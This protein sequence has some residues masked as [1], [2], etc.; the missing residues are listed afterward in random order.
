MANGLFG[1]GDGSA[2]NPY[3]IEDAADFDAIRNNL[4]KSFRMVAN[5]DLLVYTSWIPLGAY[6]GTLDGNGKILSGLT[7]RSSVYS[8]YGL[9]NYIT[10]TGVV[11]NLTITGADIQITRDGYAGVIA[12]DSNGLI[13]NCK[14]GGEMHVTL[15]TSNAMVGG[16]I[17]ETGA[18]SVIRNT[19]SS[20]NV[21][22]TDNG[23]SGS[24]SKVGG[25]VGHSANAGVDSIKGCFSTGKV[26]IVKG[27][28]YAGTLVGQL[29][30][31]MKDCYSTGDI[32]YGGGPNGWGVGSGSAAGLV[33]Y[34]ENKVTNCYSTGNVTTMVDGARDYVA[35]SIGN[36]VA[37]AV[38]VGVYWKAETVVTVQGV[39][40]APTKG[41]GSGV[42]DTLSRPQATMQSQAFLDELNLNKD[43]STVWVFDPAITNGFPTFQYAIAPA[44]VPIP[45]AP[46]VSLGPVTNSTVALS[47]PAVNGT[48]SYE[49]YKATVAGGPYTLD[50]STTNT[51]PMV[52][53]LTGSTTYYFVVKA[54][55]ASGASPN[56]NEVMATTT[57]PP[58]PPTVPPSPVL[59]V[60]AP[61]DVT[62]TS[63]LMS[64][65]SIAEAT[66]YSL[67]M[68]TI[69]GSLGTLVASGIINTYYNVTGLT[70]NTQYFFTATASN[71]NGESPRSAEMSSTTLP[72]PPVPPAPTDLAVVAGSITNTQVGLSWGASAGAAS[73]TLHQSDISGGLGFPVFSEI[74]T[75]SIQVSGLISGNTY[76]FTVTAV[77]ANGESMRSNEIT[78]TTLSPTPP[79]TTPDAP[80]A[81]LGVVTDTT[82]EVIVNS[83]PNATSYNMYRSTVSGEAI[84]VASGLIGTSYVHTG[85]TTNT[86][87]FFKAT[88][89]NSVGESVKSNE[90]SKQTDLPPA[91]TAI[92]SPPFGV[93]AGTYTEST[94]KIDWSKNPDT[95]SYSVYKS[96]VAGGPYELVVT[97]VTDL[98]YTV[99][100]L[101]SSTIYYFTVTAV[102]AIGESLMSYETTTTTGISTHPT[103]APSFPLG[104]R[105]T[106][107]SQTTVELA[108]TGVNQ[109]NRYNT[110]MATVSGGPYTLAYRG[111]IGESF[112]SAINNL[113]PGTN[114]YF[115]VTALNDIGEGPISQEVMATTVVRPPAPNKTTGLTLKS[116]TINSV[117]LYWDSQPDVLFYRLFTSQTS[118]GPWTEM[119]GNIPFTEHTVTGL[120]NGTTYFFAVAA[121]N[122][123]GRGSLSNEVSA[124][125]DTPIEGSEDAP[126][127]IYTVADLVAI[128]T[129]AKVPA[130]YKLMADLDLNVAPYN[131]GVGWIPLTDS[132]EP[133][134]Q[135]AQFVGNFDGNGH[136]IKNLYINDPTGS[137]LG[138]FRSVYP[139]DVKEQAN[140]SGKFIGST[141]KNLGLT[142][143]NIFGGSSVGAIAGNMDS[144]N[145]I[146]CYAEGTVTGSPYSDEKQ[147]GSIGGLIGSFGDLAFTYTICKVEACH[148]NG[149]VEGGAQV[150]GL[151]GL[152]GA[153]I[154]SG[155]SS[156]SIIDCYSTGTVQSNIGKVGGLV[157]E[158]YIVSMMKRCYSTSNV[159]IPSPAYTSAH[160]SKGNIGGLIGET[161]FRSN[162][163]ECCATGDVTADAGGCGGLIGH[164]S[165][166]EIFN[167]R[168]SIRDC[169][170]TGNVRGYDYCGGLLGYFDSRYTY[171]L[172]NCHSTGTVSVTVTAYTPSIGGLIGG[173]DDLV[174]N[175]YYDST[176]S[177]QSDNNGHGVPKVTAEMGTV[178]V[179]EKWDFNYTWRM[180]NTNSHPVLM[181]TTL[182]S[183][184][185]RTVSYFESVYVETILGMRA[186][187]LVDTDISDSGISIVTPKGERYVLVVDPS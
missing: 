141:I 119:V 37:S 61:M 19:S 129:N 130:S 126:I 71:A 160:L 134:S 96:R 73:Y 66:S 88:A 1:G 14:V 125:T 64:W 13:D 133:T 68:S 60:P 11:K 179:F 147:Y 49:V 72:K 54:V 46:V 101:D 29:Q 27:F 67:F 102:N 152:V 98:T 87:Y 170:A 142:G 154:T 168:G 59:N 74:A 30:S 28:A 75:T 149:A 155:Y 23:T 4:S 106:S 163:A 16:I 97:G 123:T 90:V 186:V 95:K 47:Y 143:V 82:I 161:S 117:T 167:V 85:L 78:V 139:I 17:G 140:S 35:A 32:E 137:K 39:V 2:T 127:L 138:L 20:V 113:N 70:E 107:V 156:V 128:R 183:G 12:G 110:Y 48:S 131:T 94:V 33:G 177:L 92:P 171:G 40:Q 77:N 121:V 44:P 184:S 7:L 15:E 105:V 51:S 157:G 52:G 25:L 174:H 103:T 84:L 148:F 124:R 166:S 93:A 100:G 38:I 56:S 151:I 144:C 116:V 182:V 55:N 111:M 43:A 108:W 22:F 146:N 3:L 63:I 31:E 24:P 153:R 8:D 53:G 185:P 150:G 109:A 57:A 120:A 178:G 181:W 112:N 159:S 89:V 6:S 175:C 65:G 91:P 81:S 62:P 180:D 145:L 99:T 41:V 172:D 136:V 86:L 162:I 83:V 10:D 132:T 135:Y 50:Q 169:Y 164:Y 76:Y 36:R 58:P 18:T 118:G 26:T 79:T 21:F 115:V 176:K 80:V 42:D 45:A 5:V 173:G 158:T 114:Y 165:N 69:A 104:F 34:Q 187:V 122:N 9:F